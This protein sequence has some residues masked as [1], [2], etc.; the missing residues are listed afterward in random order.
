MHKIPYVASHTHRALEFNSEHLSPEEKE[1]FCKLEEEKHR[2]EA[3][4]KQA[5]SKAEQVEVQSKVL[6]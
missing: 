4:A 3:L 2:Q 5:V 6:M 1:E